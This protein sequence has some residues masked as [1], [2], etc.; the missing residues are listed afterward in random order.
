MESILENESIRL[1]TVSAGAEMK[2]LIRKSDGQEFLWEAD[3]EFWGRTAPV[4]FPLVGK[5]KNDCYIENGNKYEMHQHGF[6]RDME[7]EIV[8]KSDKSIVY[9]LSSNEDTLKVYP[10]KFELFITYTIEGSKV[11]VEWKVINPSDDIIYFSIGGHPAFACPLDKND[12]QSDYSFMVECKEDKLVCN[13]FSDGYVTGEDYSVELKDKR[14]PIS[15]NLF[16]EDA[17][18]VENSQTKKV[19]LLDAQ[20]HKYLTVSFVS[21]VFG[22]WSPPKKN[23]PFVCIE[24]WYGRCDSIDYEGELKER[25]WGNKLEACREFKGGYEVEIF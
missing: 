16:D 10:Y 12:K 19:S 20:G 18:V 4:L 15:E 9:L 6:A 24:P 5:V 25:E 14:L 1:K 22:L 17:L 3:P 7:F 8:S 13:R 21:P 23:A 11:N 2:S